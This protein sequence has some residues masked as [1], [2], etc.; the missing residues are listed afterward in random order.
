MKDNV[1]KKGYIQVYTGNGKGKTTASLGLS[2]RAAGNG[3]KVAFV[4]FLKGRDTSEL[5]IIDKIDNIEI[6]RAPK[7]TKFFNTMN[8]EEKDSLKSN[9]LALFNEASEWVINGKYDLIVFDEILG[10]MT[11]QLISKEKLLKVLDNKNECVEVVLTGRNA[12]KWLVEKADLVSEIVPIK[13]YMNEG[14]MGRKGIE[15]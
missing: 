1:L 13:H 7:C 6:F 10:T 14:V 11:N 8:Q 12:P 2:I 4:Q 9:T 3:L 15:Y 5:A